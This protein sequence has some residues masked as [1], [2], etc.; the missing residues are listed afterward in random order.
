M[1]KRKTKVKAK[2]FTA[3]NKAIRNKKYSL[4]RWTNLLIVYADLKGVDLDLEHFHYDDFH[5]EGRNPFDV[6]ENL[7]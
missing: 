6:V 5:K 4:V 7:Q 2:N 3:R 1:G